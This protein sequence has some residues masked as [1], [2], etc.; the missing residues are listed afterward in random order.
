MRAPLIIAICWS[1]IA[2]ADPGEELSGGATTIFDATRNAFSFPARNLRESL[3]PAFFV[4][5]SFFNQNWVAAPASVAGRDGLGPLF[6]AR[7]CSACHFKDGRG[8]PPGPAEPMTTM[9]IRLSIPGHDA[10]G[11]PKAEPAYGG[12]IQGQATPGVRPEA[13]V[14]A[15]YQEVPGRFLDGQE[16]S[17]RKPVYPIRN[18]GY[19]PMAG[20]VMISPRVAPALIGMGLLEALPEEIIHALADPEDR[21]GDGI[22]GRVNLV[23]DKTAAKMLVGRFG[24]KAE[25]PTVLQ[26][27]ATAFLEDMGLTSRLMP[28]DCSQDPEVSDKVLSDVVTYTCTLAVPARRNWTDP[29][30]QRGKALFAQAYC[31]TCHVPKLRTGVYPKFPELSE[32]TIRPY[33]DLLLHDLGEGLADHRPVFQASGSEWRTAPLW[34]I[35]LISKVNGHTFFL[36][37]G[38][39]RNL[40]EAILWHGG[41]AEASREKFRALSKADRDALIAFLESL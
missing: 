6:N 28:G 20:D 19:G 17:L 9:L 34:G 4:G 21:D 40:I 35:G 33:S 5:N 30:V 18:L 32:Q 41:E 7:S 1:S 31:I 38:R 11:G 27:T 3:R 13:D 37:D 23:W 26:Q 10:H 25:Q 12:Q 29:A 8:K 15:E 16:F 2:F 22:S 24:W 39:A 36:H 14:Y